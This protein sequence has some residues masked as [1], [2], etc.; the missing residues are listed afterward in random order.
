VLSAPRSSRHTHPHRISGG[1]LP[2]GTRGVSLPLQE[3]GRCILAPSASSFVRVASHRLYEAMQGVWCV[4]H[5]AAVYSARSDASPAEA[6][7]V[8][9][10]VGLLSGFPSR[11]LVF[12]HG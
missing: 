12:V 10:R 7:Q 2:S 4:V 1:L 9:T 8:L 5:G 6:P 3:E 11:K